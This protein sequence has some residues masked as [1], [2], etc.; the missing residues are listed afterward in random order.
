MKLC[1]DVMVIANCT[2]SVASS[3]ALMSVYKPAQCIVSCSH[4]NICNLVVHQQGPVWLYQRYCTALQAVHALQHAH[5]YF[6]IIEGY[7]DVC[8]SYETRGV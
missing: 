7:G 8:S 5:M 3:H 4:Q 6:S 1:C 2:I